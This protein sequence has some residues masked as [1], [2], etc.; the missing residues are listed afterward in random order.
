MILKFRL[1]DLNTFL[2]EGKLPKNAFNSLINSY[3]Q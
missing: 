1:K 3:K 2:C